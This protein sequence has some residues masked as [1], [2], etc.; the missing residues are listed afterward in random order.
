MKLS[1]YSPKRIEVFFAI[2]QDFLKDT[3]N[4]Y[5]KKFWDTE[6]TAKNFCIA[7]C[8]PNYFSPEGFL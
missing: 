2:A 5:C 3:K 8:N 1:K 7:I 4:W 6:N